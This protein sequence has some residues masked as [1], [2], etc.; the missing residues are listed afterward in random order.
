MKLSVCSA[1]ILGFSRGV[2]TYLV[3]LLAAVIFMS[4]YNKVKIRCRKVPFAL[5]PFLA[6]SVIAAFFI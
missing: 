1:M 6:G 3:G 4:I 5:I 2:G